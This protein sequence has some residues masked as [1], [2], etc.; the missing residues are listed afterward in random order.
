MQMELQNLS[1]TYPSG[2]QALH[3]INLALK[4]P[5]LIGLLGPNGAG[6]STLM[7]LLVAALLPTQGS[8]LVDGRP[9]DRSQRALKA[10][11]GYLP[12]SF[13]LYDELTVYQFLDYMAALKGLRN[14][15][16][17]ID[18][19]IR[20]VNLEEKRRARIR[21]LSGGQR[22]RISLALAL[23][24]GIVGW[25]Q[26]QL[27]PLVEAAARA[28]AANALTAVIDRAIAADLAERDVDYGDFVTIQR[29]ASG[30]ITAMTTDMAALNQLRAQLVAQI[31]SALEGVDASE[32]R[33]P[34]GSLVDSELVWARGPELRVRALRV[35]TVS[36]EFRSDFSQAGVNQTLHRIELEVA[37][38][39]TLILPGGQTELTVETGLRVAETVIVGA[40][41]DT[42]LTLNGAA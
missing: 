20:A 35:G 18:Q 9:L 5:S 12:Q 39:V 16:S 42:Y 40:V 10:R 13:G 7:K 11:L 3:Q 15:R 32:I 17:A 26:H 25:L 21:T 38:P 36:A 22:Q 34:L 33:I 29:D 19:V 24:A 8:I 2:K 31:L 28:Q 1:M 27:R 6:K 41:P 23:A 4:A 30:A 37:V 14:S